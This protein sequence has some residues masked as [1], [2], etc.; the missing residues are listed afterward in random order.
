MSMQ[1]LTLPW[2]STKYFANVLWL[3]FMYCFYVFYSS[4]NDKN[5][6]TKGLGLIILSLGRE[7]VECVMSKTFKMFDVGLQ[8]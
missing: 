2:T 8:K 6:N 4:Q 5:S 3:L 7:T 1:W